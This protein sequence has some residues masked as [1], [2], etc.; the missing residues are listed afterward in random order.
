MSLIA[1]EPNVG[2]AL[3]KRRMTAEEFLAWDETQ[4]L[5]HEFVAGE[6][7]LMA[8]GEDRSATVA[9]NFYMALRQHL[10]GTPCRVYANDVKLRVEAADCYFYPDLMV[11]CSAEDAA[12]RL[13]KREPVLVV[14]V[15]SPSTAGFD[16]GGKFASYRALPS[17]QEY[18]LVDVDAKRCD[19][20]RLGADGLWVLHPSQGDE[21]VTLASVDLALPGA[22]IWADLE[23]EAPPE[24]ATPPTTPPPSAT[25]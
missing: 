21:M 17:L 8:G 7:F 10:K 24:A 5:R 18:L 1:A 22:V 3:E 16:R 11:T 23:G 14:E 20:H 6:V 12:S 9:G 25:V 4:T 2:Y 19:L 13:I 15:L